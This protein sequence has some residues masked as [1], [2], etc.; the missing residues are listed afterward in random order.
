MAAVTTIRLPANLVAA[1]RRADG[2]RAEGAEGHRDEWLRRLPEVI[3]DLAARWSLR[4]SDPFQPGGQTAWVAPARSERH[5]DVVLK[6]GWRHMESED[7]A[8][9]LRAWD[10]QGT[11][12]VFAEERMDQTSALLLERCRPGTM[13]K[14]RPE[15]EQ[16]LVVASLLRRLWRAPVDRAP[17]RPLQAMCDYWAG[18]FE[19]RVAASAVR[20]DPAIVR[21][22]AGLF[23][24]LPATA[25]REVLLCTDLHAE[26]V[27]A[28]TR[29]EW[30]V[31]DPKPF[32][33]DPTYDALQHILNCKDRLCAD[34]HALVA[35]VAGLLDLDAERLLVWLFARCVVETDTWPWA[36]EVAL[37]VRP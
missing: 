24:S 3:A 16:D 2:G 5:G 28:A 33:G 36:L 1:C 27:L 11:V 35:R 9:G 23:R 26:N 7:E 19:E 32:V 37:K 21:E 17:F 34:P 13:L 14:A 31:I 6:V 4:V 22:G 10:G 20:R 12:R 18:S 30:L 8:A 29:E 25:E 15:P